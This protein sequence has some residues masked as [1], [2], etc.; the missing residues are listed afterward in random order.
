MK[1]FNFKG[2]GKTRVILD[3]NFLRI[4]RKGFLNF[5]NHGMDGEKTID[6]YNMSGVQMKEAGA[7]TSGYLQFIFMGSKENKGGLFAATKDENT[8]MFIKKEQDMANEIKAYIENILANKNSSTGPQVQTG[9]ADEIRKF[10]ELLD[11]GIITEEEF[12][13]KKKELLGI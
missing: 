13:A 11:E 1:E 8:I 5:A 4:K 3:G 2:A 10:K 6:I 9:S 7:V 12:A